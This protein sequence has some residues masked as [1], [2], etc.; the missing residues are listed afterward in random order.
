VKVYWSTGGQILPPHDSNIIDKVMNAERI[1]R[2]EFQTACDQGHVSVVTAEID[3]AYL[4]AVL[5]F[6]WPGSRDCKVVF[7]PLH[8][9]GGFAVPPL[10]SAA[11]FHDVEVFQP[12]ANP[13]GDFPNVPGHVSNP[14]NPAVFDAIVDRAKAI[15]ADLVLAT[16][17]DC[18]RMGCSAPKTTAPNSDWGTLNGNQ[19]G[20]LLTDYVVA[21]QKAAGKLQPSSYVIKTLVTTELTRLIAESYGV[22]CEGNLH[23]GFKWIAGKMDDCGPESFLFGT[24]E[25]HGYLAGDHVRD[26]DGAIACLLMAELAADLKSRGVTLHQRLDELLIQH[27]V[28][29]EDQINVQMEGSEGMETMKRLMASFR[30]SPPSQIGGLP[31][32]AV[33]DFGTSTRKFANGKQEPLNAPVGEMFILDLALPGQQQPSGNAIAVRPSGTEPKIKYYLFGSESIAN[34]SEL[35][36]KKSIVKERISAMKSDLRKL[37]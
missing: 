27:G 22:R 31:V 36:E 24:E 11:G 33:R 3:A 30:H 23:V 20:A 26:K 16:D 18:D 14:E 4:K 2:T 10:L 37:G 28:F 1:L 35:E 7:S 15:G 9:V 21:K 19:I 5:P 25:S 29:L 8:G 12:H 34:A 17:P 6:A 13:D 32:A